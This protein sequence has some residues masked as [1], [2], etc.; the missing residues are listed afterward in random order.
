M[1]MQN[2]KI[3]EKLTVRRQSSNFCTSRHLSLE[4]I[5]D[6]IYLLAVLDIF[7]CVAMCGCVFPSHE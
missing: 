4:V 3:R 7:V 5:L 1:T 2:L 6:T